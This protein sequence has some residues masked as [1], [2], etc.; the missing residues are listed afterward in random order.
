MEPKHI[1]DDAQH[2]DSDDINL[3]DPF[4]RVSYDVCSERAWK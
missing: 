2:L 4:V 1:P 3:K